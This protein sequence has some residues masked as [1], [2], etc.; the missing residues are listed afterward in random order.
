MIA[1][2]GGEAG[3]KFSRIV[4]PRE[5]RNPEE[6]LLRDAQNSSGIAQTTCYGVKI[7]LRTLAAMISFEG[8]EFPHRTSR[9]LRAYRLMI[10]LW[11][12]SFMRTRASWTAKREF[13]SSK[14]M[15]GPDSYLPS[16]WAGQGTT[17]LK[18][19]RDLMRSSKPV[20]HVPI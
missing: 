12:A 10:K 14:I 1:G 7:C 20:R 6:H 11:W 4:P 2:G 13:S 17:L 16:F 15:L 3:G 19:Q 8:K 5:L 9:F 18:Q